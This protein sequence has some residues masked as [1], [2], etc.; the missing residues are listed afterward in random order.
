MARIEKS[1]KIN[2]A[3]EKAFAFATDFN[4]AATWQEGVIEAKVTSE[5][6]AGYGL[7]SSCWSSSSF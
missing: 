4:K 3:P 6:A 7:P 5:R 1:I 2:C